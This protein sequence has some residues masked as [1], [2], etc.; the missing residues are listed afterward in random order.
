MLCPRCVSN[1]DGQS[2]CAPSVGSEAIIKRGCG[3][4]WRLQNQILRK[5]MRWLPVFQKVN[6]IT[7]ALVVVSSYQV[8]FAEEEAMR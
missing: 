8:K 1:A 4:F 5:A 7:H 6:R 2:L 3:G